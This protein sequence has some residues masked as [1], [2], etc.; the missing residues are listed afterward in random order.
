MVSFGNRRSRPAVRPPVGGALRALS[1]VDRMVREARLR[2]WGRR[3]PLPGYSP[4]QPEPSEA[5]RVAALEAQEHHER[6]ADR[7]NLL[8][9]DSVV[10]T[11]RS[12]VLFNRQADRRQTLLAGG[13]DERFE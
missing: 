7:A 3:Y 6:A 11:S 4:D 10:E 8:E 13:T 9:P 5:C 2:P 12:V 1:Y